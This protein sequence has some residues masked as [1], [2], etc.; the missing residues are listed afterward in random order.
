[1]AV[2]QDTPAIDFS[3][4]RSG[5]EEL[6]SQLSGLLAGEHNR[7]ANAANM[8]ALLYGALPDVNWVG[9][10]FLDFTELVVGPFQGKPACV[11]IPMGRGV[12]GQAAARR[13]TILVRDVHAFSDHIVCDVA[14]NSEIVVP[15]IRDGELLGVLDLDSPK[16]ARFDDED[17]AGIE[18]LAKIYLASL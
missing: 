14:S 15:L 8:T 5:Y 16:L 9:F 11:R 2:E 6:A 7:V 4:K 10:Y 18:R 13:E 1:L 17:R 12:C 3:H